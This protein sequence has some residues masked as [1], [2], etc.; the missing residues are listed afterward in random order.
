M[1]ALVALVP[2][3]PVTR[4]ESVPIVLVVPA[5]SKVIG[6]LNGAFGETEFFVCVVAGTYPLA[7]T[8]AGL[9]LR[10]A[11]VVY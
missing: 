8:I 6:Y 11:E 3:I 9:P 2:P 5:A 4:S 1:L 10:A 7:I